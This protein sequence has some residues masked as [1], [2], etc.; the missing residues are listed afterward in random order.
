MTTYTPILAPHDQANAANA[1]RNLLR[2]Y[3]MPGGVTLYV[4][5]GNQNTELHT[6]C[7]DL[8]AQRGLEALPAL[9]PIPNYNAFKAQTILQELILI[10]NKLLEE[11]NV[12]RA[13]L[14][15]KPRAE[16]KLPDTQKGKQG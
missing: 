6:E 10:N 4:G 1:A 8:R 16:Y 15:L 11:V 7:N 9:A 2:R 13:A 5:L 3:G 12:H 14:G